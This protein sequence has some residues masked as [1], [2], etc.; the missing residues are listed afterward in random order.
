MSAKDRLPKDDALRSNLT[1]LL[2]NLNKSSVG[3]YYPFRGE[4]EV[5]QVAANSR[6][7]TSLPVCI[8]SD[9]EKRLRFFAWHLNEPLI[10]GKY[11]IAVPASLSEEIEPEI[12]VLPCV[13][14]DSR[15]F[16]LGYGAGWYDRTL[17]LLDPNVMRVG[18]AYD[19]F[20]FTEDLAEGHD[21]PM[22][23]VVSESGVRF[24]KA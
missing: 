20:E 8:D 14:F 11:G 18:V 21:E 7:Q 12:I 6:L 2:S 5:L 10:P 4:P 3:L 16:R 9:T 17:P 22:H 1:T 24:F 13:G 23:A 15:G 19:C